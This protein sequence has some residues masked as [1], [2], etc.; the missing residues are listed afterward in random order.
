MQPMIEAAGGLL[1]RTGAGAGSLEVALVH[2]SR[3]DDWTLPKG[4]L[5]SGETRQAAAIREVREETGFEARILGF[6]GVV[7]Y[8]TS[9]G[10][11]V[12]YFW[13]MTPADRGGGNLDESEVTAVRWLHPRQAQKKL[14]YPLE[15][16]ILS[17]WEEFAI[18]F[19]DGGPYRTSPMTT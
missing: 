3:Y 6:A 17:A 19:G 4:K 8:E 9:A 7:A 13:N 18:G 10:P 15:Q 11:K 16:A 5:R 1:W 12:V 2:R 14:T